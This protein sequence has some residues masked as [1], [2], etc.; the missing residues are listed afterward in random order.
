MSPHDR[1]RVVIVDGYSTGRELVRELLARNVE[2][3]HLRSTARLP[4]PVAGCFDPSPY[5]ADLGHVGD[6]VAA[7]KLLAPLA[8]Q[9]VVAGSEWG[10]TFAEQV[11]H[12]L[13]LP[14]NRI[15]K[16]GVRRDKFDMIEA[17]RRRGL[18]VARQ[19]AVDTV[20]EAQ[21]WARRHGAWPVVVKPLTSAG[22]DGVYICNNPADIHAAFASTLGRENFMGCVNRRLLLQSYLSGPQF[23]VNTVSWR[24]RHH[25][26]DAWSMSLAA[27]GRQVVPGGAHLLDPRRPDAQRLIEYTLE[28]LAALG[29]ENGAAH[30]ELRWTPEGPALIETGARLMGAA[31]DEPSYSAAGMRTQADIFAGVLAD[32]E[33]ERD[34]LFAQGCYRF[35]R[36]MTKL[37]FNFT[38]EGT[39]RG[40]EGLRHL[41]SL[42]SFHAHYRG[43]ARGDQVARTADWLARGG[44]IYLVHDDPRQIAS[45]IE[46]IRRWEAR[47]LLYDV[48][49]ATAV[50]I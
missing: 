5:D 1:K 8:P 32:R 18:H 50:A 7:A 14:T 20:E 27:A 29:I 39:I 30:T 19:A 6:A 3:L 43:L 23:I 49:P 15:K 4:A 26:S 35:H 21:A 42:A 13:G 11:A 44:V 24:G 12:E 38:S 2:C 33:G 9:A 25:V 45:D 40:I 28:V 22:A 37:L 48:Q 41:R 16:L 17:A 34:R 47:G 31:M 10:V 36:H 46:T